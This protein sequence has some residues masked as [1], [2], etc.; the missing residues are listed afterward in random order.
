[1]TDPESALAR[2]R[3]EAESMRESGA[4]ADDLSRYQLETPDAITT[5]KLFEWGMIDPD[6]RNVRS[7]RR[8]GAPITALKHGLLRLLSQYHGEL[9]A[10]QIRFNL[11]LVTFLRQLED[12]IAE[13]E[14]ARAR[15]ARDREGRQ[16]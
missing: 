10:E 8:L 14:R 3:E 4:Y 1:M 7:T 2:A 11:H 6:L 5:G 15:E 9:I 16:S 13:L 12:R